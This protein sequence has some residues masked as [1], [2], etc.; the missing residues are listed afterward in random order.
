[1]PDVLRPPWDA[2]LADVDAAFEAPFELHCLGGFVIAQLHDFER[3]TVDVDII[4]V[5]GADVRAV[6]ALAGKGSRLHRRHDVYMDV[7]TVA[8]VPDRYEERLID[9]ASGTFKYLRLRALEPHDLVLA[10]LTRNIDRDRE[11]VKR[12]A[13]RGL[14]HAHVL[15]SRYESELRDQLGRPERE[16]LTLDLW[17]DMI[18]EVGREG[19]NET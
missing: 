19:S 9:L 17:I 15:R 12:L 11:D 13:A 6:A 14:L 4:E 8:A 1:M 16:D 10:K 2:F 5:R 18:D 3:V 7:V